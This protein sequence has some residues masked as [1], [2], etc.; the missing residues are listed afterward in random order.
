MKKELLIWLKKLL[1]KGI[2]VNTLGMGL[3]EGAPIPIINRY[4]QKEYKK[5][6]MEILLFQ[7]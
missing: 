7:N 6:K 1:E 4:N 2:V 3:A 5:D